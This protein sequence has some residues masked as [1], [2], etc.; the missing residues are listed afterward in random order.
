MSYQWQELLDGVWT[1]LENET[2]TTFTISTM[3]NSFD[4]RKFRVVITNGGD[5]FISNEAELRL[6]TP[7]VITTQPTNVSIAYIG[8]NAVFSVEVSGYGAKYQWYVS[9]NYGADTGVEI[10]GATSNTLSVSVENDLILENVY[11]CKITNAKATL[12]TDMV[13]VE[14][15]QMLSAFQKWSIENGLG[16]DASPS[17]MPYN[18]GITNLEKFAFGLDASKATSYEANANFKYASDGTSA[19]LEFPVGVD[20]EGVVNVKALKSS[21]LINWAETTATATGETTQDGKFKIYKITVP[22]DASEGKVFL[23]LKVE[24]KK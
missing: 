18:D 21:D 3:E 11:L 9:G 6:A 19:S 14:E 17:A 23:K 10:M 2:A 20:A 24:E 7:I 4:G 13:Y 8:K 1:N 22:V 15:V 12:T 5:E 16:Y